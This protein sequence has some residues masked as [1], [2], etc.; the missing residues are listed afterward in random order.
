MLFK[1]VGYEMGVVAF[2]EDCV[3][4][5]D[6]KIYQGLQLAIE[7]LVSALAEIFDLQSLQFVRQMKLLSDA[8]SNGSSALGTLK[9]LRDLEG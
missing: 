1:I 6:V 4:V 2:G 3:L 9:A 5:E 7:F 8:S